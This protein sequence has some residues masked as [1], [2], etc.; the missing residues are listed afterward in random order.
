MGSSSRSVNR[1]RRG[2]I[3]AQTPVA[4]P[5]SV[6]QLSAQAAVPISKTGT[7]Q[8]GLKQLEAKGRE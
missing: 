7:S 2:R 3:A 6:A 4:H 8:P 1:R 5:E